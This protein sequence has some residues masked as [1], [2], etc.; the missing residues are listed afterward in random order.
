MNDI[1]SGTNAEFMAEC[2]KR[3]Y[4]EKL[5]LSKNKKSTQMNEIEKR[6]DEIVENNHTYKQD[7]D[8]D[9]ITNFNSFMCRQELSTYITSLLKGRYTIEQVKTCVPDKKIS[10]YIKDDF[11]RGIKA[12]KNN[13]IDEMEQNIAKLCK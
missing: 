13:T 11:L 1:M 5:R 8:G 9:I 10:E 4:E 3:D 7:C 12:G 6:I 2:D